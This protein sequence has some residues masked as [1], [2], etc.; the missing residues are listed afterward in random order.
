MYAVAWGRGGTWVG[1]GVGRKV[2][3]ENEGGIEHGD[4]WGGVRLGSVST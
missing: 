3:R 2:G 4:G 1:D